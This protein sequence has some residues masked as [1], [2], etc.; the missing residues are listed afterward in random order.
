MRLIQAKRRLQAFNQI[1]IRSGKLIKE[2]PG[3]DRQAF[4]VLTL[5]F[6]IQRING[7]RTFA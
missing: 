6:G 4:D 2:L 5:A 1:N 7:K 3:V